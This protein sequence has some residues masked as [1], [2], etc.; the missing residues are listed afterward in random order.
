[1]ELP[2]LDEVFKNQD[3]V[4]LVPDYYFYTELLELPIGLDAE[5]IQNYAEYT[6]EDSSPFPVEQLYWGFLTNQ[7]DASC[8]LL[9][10]AYKPR[11][12]APSPVLQIIP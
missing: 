2:D 12:K 7:E 4:I 3:K 9:Y 11:L 8:M 1:M 5:E 6:L 10:A